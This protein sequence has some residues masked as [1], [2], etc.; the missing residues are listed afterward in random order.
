MP[1]EADNKGRVGSPGGATGSRAATTTAGA[2]AIPA[3]YPNAPATGAGGVPALPAAVA[4]GAGNASALVRTEGAEEPLPE[5]PEEE[6]RLGRLPMQ[7]DVM[8]KIHSFRVQDL[9]ALEKGTVVE[10]VHEHSQDVPVRCGG[11]PLVWAEFEV[12]DQQLAV[13]ITRLA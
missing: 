2:G 8:V 7:L 1:P 12:L 3:V 10:T 5:E 11:A 13:R 4:G 9:L 6:T